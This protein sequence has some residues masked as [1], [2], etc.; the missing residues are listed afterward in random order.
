MAA[1]VALAE[2]E[3]RLRMV[4]A[5]APIILFALDAAGVFTLVE[6]RGLGALHVAPEAL[7]GLSVFDLFADDHTAL[8]EFRSAL[9]GRPTTFLQTIGGVVFEHR[10]VPLAGAGGGRAGA[11][12]VAIDLSERVAAEGALRRSEETVRTLVE[13][14]PVGICITDERGI[15]EETNAAYCA[16]YGYPRQDL[17]G[18]LFTLIIPEEAREAAASLYEQR[19]THGG[20]LHREFRVLRRD[21]QIRTIL[22]TSVPLTGEDGRPK[23]VSFVVDIT[24]RSR[25]EEAVRRSERHLALQYGAVGILAEAE[26]LEAALPPLLRA[27]GVALGWQASGFWVREPATGRLRFADG[28]CE[29]DPGAADFVLRSRRMEFLSGHG[30]PGQ[31]RAGGA[32]LWVADVTAEPTF[33]RADLA[34]AAGLHTGVFLP[35]LVGDTVHGVLECLS[36]EVLPPDPELLVALTAIGSQIGQLVDRLSAAE[37][38]R[39]QALH[40]TLSG[41]PNRA[42]LRDRL[43]LALATTAR[44]GAGL[45]LLLLDLNRFKAVND[46]YGHQVGDRLLQ[47]VATRVRSTLRASDTV[48]RLGGDEFAVLLPDTDLI[49]AMAAA[50]AIHA[51]ITRP[52]IVVEGQPLDVGASIGVSLAPADA[53]AGEELLRMADLAMYAAKRA[54]GGSV[55]YDAEVDQGNSQRRSLTA[56]LRRALDDDALALHYQPQVALATGRPLGVEALLRWPHPQH[57]LLPG[58]RFLSLADSPDLVLPLASWV[59]DTALRQHAAWRGEFG[60]G[61]E[62]AVNISPLVLADPLLPSTVAWLLRLHAVPP[63]C[64]ALE[65][66]E[67]TIAADPLAVAEQLAALAALGVRIVLDDV[68]TGTLSLAVLQRLPLSAL[69]IDVQFMPRLPDQPGQEAIVRAIIQMGHSLGLHAVAEGIEDGGTLERLRALGCDRGQGYYLGRPL[70]A[71]DLAA[72]WRKDR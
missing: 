3:A 41:L 10:L 18:K 19:L 1:E 42:L 53:T 52:P 15:F 67:D 4:T 33:R 12:G 26:T 71:D 70:P 21:G 54:G 24:E 46:S 49:G 64:L 68:G 38:L 16:L 28:W 25:M 72:W 44:T 66:T 2:S 56:E 40:D 17:I 27:I 35:V 51:A 6:G 34:A 65:I 7:V 9:A 8:P 29:G 69:K 62:M 23:R 58:G 31:V 45:A 37:A 30:L 39:Y 50:R 5:S 13:T 59:L 20:D 43:E 14:A 11:I 63:A 61:I 22:S 48:A 55:V 60:E 47:E 32:P 57:G 36:V